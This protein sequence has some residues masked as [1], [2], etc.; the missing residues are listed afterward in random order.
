V[1]RRH[2]RVARVH[3]PAF[4]HPDRRRGVSELA[5]LRGSVPEPYKRDLRT[6]DYHLIDAGHFAL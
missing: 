6:L 3:E 1:D 2:P 4:S 5:R